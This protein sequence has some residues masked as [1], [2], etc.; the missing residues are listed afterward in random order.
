MLVCHCNMITEREVEQT[1]IQ[2]LKQ[3]PWHLIVPAKVYHALEKRG[4]CCGCFPKV[5]ETI[6]RVTQHY[7]SGAH[8]GGPDI[9]SHRTAPSYKQLDADCVDEAE[10]H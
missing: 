4:R 8:A 1:I 6:I 2:L 9:V 3:D 5:V 10:S 7:H